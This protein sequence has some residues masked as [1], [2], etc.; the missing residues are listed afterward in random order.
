MIEETIR[1]IRE[2]ESQAESLV[3]K[4]DED[5]AAILADARAEAERAKAMAQMEANDNA[6]ALFAAEREAG[7]RAAREA[8]DETEKDISVLKSNAKAKEGEVISA[9]IAEL[10]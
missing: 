3:K 10:V 2:T 7:E 1:A 6:N 9:V 5:C 8:L 4:A